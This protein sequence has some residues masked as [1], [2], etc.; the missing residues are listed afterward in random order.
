MCVHIGYNIDWSS[1]MLLIIWC[2]KKIGVDNPKGN[3]A[4]SKDV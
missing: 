1:S 2:Q 3:Y 4:F